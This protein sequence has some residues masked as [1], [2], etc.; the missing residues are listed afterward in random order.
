MLLYV[1]KSIFVGREIYRF[2]MMVYN[3]TINILNI[4][5]VP[6]LFRT[7]FGRQIFLPS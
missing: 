6:V 7:R 3:I 4:I 1:N 2:V 5:H